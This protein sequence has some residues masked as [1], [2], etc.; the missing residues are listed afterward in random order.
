MPEQVDIV[1]DGLSAVSSDTDQNRDVLEIIA[2]RFLED[3]RRLLNPQIEDYARL[4][5]DQADAIRKVFPV[6]LRLER[7]RDAATDRLRQEQFPHSLPI[8]RLAQYQ[9]KTETNRTAT[10]IVYSAF[11]TPTSDPVN[12]T[13]VPWKA[14]NVQRLRLQ[15]ERETAIARRLQHSG[16]MPVLNV[17]CDA[18]YFFYVTPSIA[19]IDGADL[20]TRFTAGTQ[21]WGRISRGDWATF[22]HLG[23][24]LGDAL[25]YAHQM[26][27]LHNDI[28]PGN[29]FVSRSANARLQN[30]RLEQCVQTT[31]RT[32][33]DNNAPQVPLYV[34]PECLTG[35]R[36]ERSDIYSLGATLLIM[37]TQSSTTD[38]KPVPR[39]AA[40]SWTN[41]HRLLRG[42]GRNMPRCFSQT[43]QKA[44]SADPARRFQSAAEF[45][46][47][48]DSVRAT[49][50]ERARK[51]VG[52]RNRVRT[53]ASRLC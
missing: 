33:F 18:G 47:A 2:S 14:D 36:D 53:W 39:T 5:R 21:R 45:A 11:H 12:I 20:I 43:L 37:A 25:N 4:H 35:T 17:G 51:P 8:T 1:L 9:L 28:R 34:A 40:V 3:Y 13:V 49:L 30:F 50:T 41:S 32:N 26:G 31:L 24:Q 52:M 29:V 15:L 27:T 19:G 42:D 23:A 10:T 46:A 44:M 22:S 48:L 6:L 38:R 16:I 7:K